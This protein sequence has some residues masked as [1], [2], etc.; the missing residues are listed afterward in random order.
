MND[1]DIRDYEL[2]LKKRK[3]VMD[4]LK[5]K[6]VEMLR[7]TSVVIFIIS[8]I[9]SFFSLLDYNIPHAY[10][11]GEKY[12]GT[13][14]KVTFSILLISFLTMMCCN[15]YLNYLKAMKEIGE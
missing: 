5:I 3:K 14:S 8:I 9:I 15:F 4:K 10:S 6:N 1:V 13:I 2:Y 7:D 12:F 11:N